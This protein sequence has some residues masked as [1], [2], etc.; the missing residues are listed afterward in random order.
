[1]LVSAEFRSLCRLK[2]EDGGAAAGLIQIKP[3]Y[4]QTHTHTH[5]HTRV[6]VR[7][8]VCVTGQC[9][10]HSSVCLLTIAV[11]LSFEGVRAV[12]LMC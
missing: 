5:T 2:C 10:G 3:D 12:T 8:T 1:M 4:R 7:E 11:Y 9:Q 6:C